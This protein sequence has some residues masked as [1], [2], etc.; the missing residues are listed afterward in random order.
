MAVKWLELNKFGC[1]LF[2]LKD[3]YNENKGIALKIVDKDL[4]ES[5]IVLSGIN[6]F[7]YYFLED[8]K[9][10]LSHSSK[11]NLKEL[12]TFIPR[13]S[14]NEVID[15]Q[16]IPCLSYEENQPPYAKFEPDSFAFAFAKSKK[17][18]NQE[19]LNDIEKLTESFD[20]IK[21]EEFKEDIF[22]NSQ[23]EINN[24]I[25]PK[26]E[27]KE[28]LLI[29]NIDDLESFEPSLSS[30][31]SK[32]DG[33]IFEIMYQE[34]LKRQENL[35][36]SKINNL[37]KFEQPTVLKKEEVKLNIFQEQK[38]QENKQKQRDSVRF[39]VFSFDNNSIEN[40]KKEGL[41]PFVILF[42]KTVLKL[43]ESHKLV[44][45]NQAYAKLDIIE[46]V[47]IDNT[48][49]NDVINKMKVFMGE[50]LHCEV[51]LFIE[52]WNAFIKKGEKI[53]IKKIMKEDFSLANL[54][55]IL[56]QI[57]LS[58]NQY[59]QLMEKYK[60]Y[61]NGLYDLNLNLWVEFGLVK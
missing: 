56:H 50:N 53:S 30:I 11:F 44:M 14:I 28:K 41:D 40:Y 46:K 21:Q 60:K 47:S 1:Q 3:R 34:Y 22:L 6:T 33:V 57:S 2:L 20:L 42:C 31:N 12:K 43:I 39:N 8:K 58:N 38:I 37:K 51:G 54:Y 5:S 13:V 18:S 7:F 9:M 23:D 59:K 52:N 35:T 4:F 27:I 24:E 29:T 45:M 15:I 49:R 19:N 17:T 26:E 25:S 10:Y 16:D 55:F 36:E 32:K 61:K 48:T